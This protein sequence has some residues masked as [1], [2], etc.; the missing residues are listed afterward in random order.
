MQM[1]GGWDLGSE[2]AM[3]GDSTKGPGLLPAGPGR[4][5]FC[6]YSCTTLSTCA[7]R[8]GLVM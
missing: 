3:P 6:R 8:K 2:A 4:A 1:S 7:M 5:Y